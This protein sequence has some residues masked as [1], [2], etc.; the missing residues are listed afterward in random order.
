[1][2][3]YGVLW[4]AFSG[5]AEGKSQMLEIL[6]GRKGW[7]ANSG[8]YPC[9]GGSK[10]PQPP[11]SASVSPSRQYETCMYNLSSLSDLQFPSNISGR[12]ARLSR[13]HRLFVVLILNLGYGASLPMRQSNQIGAQWQRQW[14]PTRLGQCDESLTV[15]KPC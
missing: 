15:W 2:T 5:E 10:R 7:S 13:P 11:A 8:R 14:A 1:M 4:D 6:W 12:S 3:V 9:T